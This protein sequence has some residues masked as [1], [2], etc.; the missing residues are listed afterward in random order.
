MMQVEPWR[1]S[2]VLC[3]MSFGHRKVPSASSNGSVALLLLWPST[4]LFPWASYSRTNQCVFFL[5]RTSYVIWFISVWILVIELWNSI[6]FRMSAG[7]GKS[8]VQLPHFPDS[9][10]LHGSLGPDG[11][12][13]DTLIASRLTSIQNHTILL[14][15][16]AGS[17][18]VLCH[19]PCQYK[20][21]VQQVLIF[22]SNMT[23]LLTLP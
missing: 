13:Q 8:W 4:S 9:D 20:P 7:D 11:H 21:T 22:N 10:S 14:T 18:N 15:F 19:G 5:P 16:C 3:T 1:N 6:I 23:W 12:F 17:S 2:G